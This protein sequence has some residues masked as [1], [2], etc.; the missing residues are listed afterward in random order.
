[1]KKTITIISSLAMVV[2]A[3]TF[4]ISAGAVTDWDLTG[5]YTIAFTCTSGCGGTYPH[6]M[7]VT[8]MDLGSGNFSGTGHYI[9]LPSITWTVTGNVV[10]SNVTF[11][12]DYDG[13]SYAVHAIGIIAPDGSMSGTATGPGQVFTWSIGPGAADNDSDDDRVLNGDDLCPNTPLTDGPWSLGWGTNR[14]QVMVNEWYQNKPAKT[15]GEVAPTGLTIE[16]TFGCN[17]KQILDIITGV[18]GLP[19]DGHYKYGPS[20]SV[21]MDFIADY[22]DG[23]I[24]GVDKT[25]PIETV[26]VPADD[27]D[28]VL[29]N[30]TLESGKTYL[31]KASGTGDACVTGCGYSILFD[32]E[33][34]TSDGG[35]TWVDGVAAPYTSYGPD[36]LDLMV[37]GG[38]VDWDT[39]SVYNADHTY[40]QEV[41]GTGA[42]VSLQVYDV[43]YPNNSG[44]LMVDI[45]VKL[46]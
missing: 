10:G 33:Y 46:Y 25:N 35:T 37:D 3:F 17:G 40:W 9:P 8:L 16:D 34:S 5:T 45:F 12:I 24:D 31:L 29:S 1:M 20:K 4:P 42:P 32:P 27:T 13:S 2:S 41:A 38:F 14:W 36:L 11:D 28:G 15:G 30:S 7:T 26:T 39:D 22:N 23:V 43:Y 6:S 44:N 21:V 18:T 19:F